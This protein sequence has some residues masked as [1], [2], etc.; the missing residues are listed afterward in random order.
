VIAVEDTVL[1][2]L[3]AGRSTRW[4]GPH[5]KLDRPLLGRPLGLH[6]A[7]TLSELPFLAR[8]AVTGRASIDYGAHGFETVANPDPA[9]GLA[10][11]LHLGIA[12]ARASGAAAVLVA[13]ADMP[14]VTAA[15]V[16]RL[17]DATDDADGVVA[18][19]DGHDGQ[20]PAIFG[21]ER[22]DALLGLAGDTGARALIAAGRHVVTSPAELIDIDTP[23]AFD[24]LRKDLPRPCSDGVAAI[25]PPRT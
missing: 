4:G 23:A 5:S 17:F 11:S 3:A 20:P 14:C 18:S 15:H 19:S 2:L 21:R 8:V 25:P 12:R 10:G 24:R 1:V 22:F 7:D 9:S 16:R 6:F 13:L